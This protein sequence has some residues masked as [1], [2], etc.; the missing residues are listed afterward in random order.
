MNKLV[1][2]SICL[3]F[4]LTVMISSCSK[5][6]LDQPGLPGFRCAFGNAEYVADSAYYKT[7]EAGVTGT[8]I[9]VYTGGVQ[10]FQFFLLRTTANT[11]ADSI[12]T[13][14]LDSTANIAYCINNGT[15][16]RS[17]SGSLTISQ[18]YNDS[19]KMISGSFSFNGRE[20]GSSGNSLNFTYG[21]FNDIPRRY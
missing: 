9:Y 11:L 13:Y 17:I 5:T 3:L 15:K 4:T 18:Y 6:N 14:N 1:I 21:Y 10:K 19:L 16:Y 8:N 7:R 12:G 20:P 2:L